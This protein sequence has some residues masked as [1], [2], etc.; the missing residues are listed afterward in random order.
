[1][2]ILIIYLIGVFLMPIVIRFVDKLD[3]SKSDKNFVFW[4]SIVW[5][6]TIFAV[7]L[8]LCDEYVVPTIHKLLDKCKNAFYQIYKIF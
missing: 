4:V 7:L 6:I 1:M 3:N 5:F 8:F 2:K